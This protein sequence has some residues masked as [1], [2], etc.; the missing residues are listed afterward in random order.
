MLRWGFQT[1]MP[2]GRSMLRNPVEARKASNLARYR[3]H[4]PATLERMGNCSSMYCVLPTAP[5]ILTP[6]AD[7]NFLLMLSPVWQPQLY[8]N[9]SLAKMPRL[10]LPSSFS[11]SQA[12]DALSIMFE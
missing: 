9:A 3:V 11:C 5:I 6:V 12:F 7:A 8:T 1:G 10:S 2:A 4:R